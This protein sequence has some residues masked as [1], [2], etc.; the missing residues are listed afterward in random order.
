MSEKLTGP[1][2]LIEGGISDSNL[3]Y[4]CGFTAPDAT[5]YLKKGRRS[6]LVV[7]M[8][9]AGRAHRQARVNEVVT[10]Q[11]LSVSRRH[12]RD[13][14]QWAL[15]LL[16][17]EHIRKVS[18]SAEFPVAAADLLRRNGVRVKVTEGP[19]FPEREI[20]TKKEIEHI[21]KTQKAAAVAMRHAMNRI[22]ES[23]ISSG[24]YLKIGTRRLTSEMVRREIEKTL[25]DHDC[26][27]FDIIVAG[28]KQSADPHE[29]GY[30]P[31]KS[32]EPIVLDIFPRH[33]ISG[34]W[35][36]M[37]RTVVRGRASR[38]LKN[39]FKAV[40]TAQQ[41]ALSWI[42]PGQSTDWI[43]EQ[44]LSFFR[45]HGF[46]TQIR[47]KIPEGFIHGVG[48]GVGLDIHEAPSISL[49]SSQILAGQV[50]TIEPGLYYPH[51]GGVRIEDTVVVTSSGWR[52]LA[53]CPK[54][55]EL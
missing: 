3:R 14:H 1:V 44:V 32:G 6:F 20:K 39:M 31:L 23:T 12:R 54:T 7:S 9:E 8:L 2:L 19:L 47:R 49:A 30:G 24:G 50:I 21:R 26:A 18:V 35:G 37:T 51:L 36:D 40:K 33:R 11:S 4:A 29:R 46:P 15:A 22:Q 52:Y 45:E 28:G 55:F 53:T 10:P 13:I 25:C 41:K 17:R 43:Y 38:D 34:Y 5:V 42:K 48:H 27:A 16:K